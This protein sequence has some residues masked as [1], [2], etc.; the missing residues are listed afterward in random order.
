[1]V[2]L[3]A[4]KPLLEQRVDYFRINLREGAIAVENPL[5]FEGLLIKLIDGFGLSGY[6]R[7]EGQTEQGGQ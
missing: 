4:R 1:M 5:F 7:R 2:D 6:N 3:N